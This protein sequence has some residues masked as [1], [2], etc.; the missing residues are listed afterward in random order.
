MWSVAAVN[1]MFL[2]TSSAPKASISYTTTIRY[3]FYHGPVYATE[4]S[5]SWFKKALGV[6]S[7]LLVLPSPGH[8]RR[9]R[10]KHNFCV[11]Q[12]PPM[13]PT[14]KQGNDRPIA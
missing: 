3:T 10:A 11:T 12:A 8:K 2:F 5:M 9:R 13:H 4:P 14:G 6:G 1:W 7:N